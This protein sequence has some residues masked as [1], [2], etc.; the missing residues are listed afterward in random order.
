MS[1]KQEK[2]RVQNDMRKC[3]NHF[4]VTNDP[5]MF[6][7]K[8]WWIHSLRN[9]SEFLLFIVYFVCGWTAQFSTEISNGRYFVWF[10]SLSSLKIETMFESACSS[11]VQYQSVYFVIVKWKQL[12]HLGT[13]VSKV[14]SVI[15]EQIGQ[16]L[17]N[18]IHQFERENPE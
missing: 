18:S 7:E 1:P 16:N 8:W 2:K 14:Q 11:N 13:R 4:I 10:S 5:L 6:N 17:N 15:S 9:L 3:L 12:Y